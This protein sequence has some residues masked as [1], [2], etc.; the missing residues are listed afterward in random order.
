MSLMINL[1]GKMA[2]VTEAAVGIGR[3]IAEVLVQS[4]ATVIINDIDAE[5]GQECVATLGLKFAAHYSLSEP[6]DAHHPH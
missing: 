3:G 6:W 5:R 1:T 4:G 2:L